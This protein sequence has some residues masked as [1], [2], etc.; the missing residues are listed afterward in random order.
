[1]ERHHFICHQV[2]NS[3]INTAKLSRTRWA[4][5]LQ[6]TFLVQLARPL[7]GILKGKLRSSCREKV[8]IL[9]FILIFKRISQSSSEEQKS[10]IYLQK[11]ETR[12]PV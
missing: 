11:R 1:M 4:L 12:P 7:L 3:E 10:G 2:L 8:I 6:A 5:I 9:T